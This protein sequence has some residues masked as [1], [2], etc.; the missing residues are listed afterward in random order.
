[1]LFQYYYFNAVSTPRVD[2]YV[3]HIRAVTLGIVL[4]SVKI[5]NVAIEE[6]R[7]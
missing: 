1:M 3:S 6:C 2:L 4:T 5:V 7:K